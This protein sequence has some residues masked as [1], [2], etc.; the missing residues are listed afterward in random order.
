MN[1]CRRCGGFVPPN[2]DACPNC[3]IPSSRWW[4]LPLATAGAGFMSL[5]LAA[6]YGAP[7]TV[8]LPDGGVGSG[9]C[10]LCNDPLPDGGS[11]LN[12]PNDDFCFQGQLPRPDGGGD[13][14]TADGGATDGG[15]DAGP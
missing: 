9:S 12:D 15:A 3:R 5:T 13:G 14:G 7:C 11:R 10:I 1:Q 4:L 8:A 6:C 2:Q